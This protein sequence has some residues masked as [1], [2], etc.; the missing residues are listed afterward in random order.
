[1]ASVIAKYDAE[2]AYVDTEMARLVDFFLEN[3]ERG[4]SLV[5]ITSDHGEG[6]W[7]HGERYHDYSTYEEELRVPFLLLW[8][9]RLPEGARSAQPAH[10]IDLVPTLSGLLGIPFS[11]EATEGIDLLPYID[12]TAAADPERAIFLQRPYFPEGRPRYEQSGYGFAVRVG[13]WKYFE[14]PDE[15][16]RQL[17]DLVNDPGEEKNLA[18]SRPR[19]V[20]RLSGLIAEWRERQERNRP[21]RELE[22]PADALEGLRA[23]GYVDSE[24]EQAPASD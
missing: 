5:I 11:G 23:L 13:R 7:D 10:L 3:D 14:A 12:G 2:A 22:V 24:S 20:K 9:G 8:P 17:F 16:R 15:N 19:V 21:E 1:M 4:G 6:L 18:A